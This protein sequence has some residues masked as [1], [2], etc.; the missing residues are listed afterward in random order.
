M[1]IINQDVIVKIDRT[2]PVY[3]DGIKYVHVTYRP[4]NVTPSGET[5]SEY[6]VLEAA[7]A[8]RAKDSAYSNALYDVIK[9][10]GKAYLN[11]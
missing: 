2:F 6:T 7:W 11:R 3:K 4:T 8:H 10:N 5:G 9:G 1:S